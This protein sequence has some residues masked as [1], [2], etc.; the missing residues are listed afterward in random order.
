MRLYII[1]NIPKAK[2]PSPAA[3]NMDFLV[4]LDLKVSSVMKVRIAAKTK[5]FT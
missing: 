5:N 3:F 4:S 1:E 2:A